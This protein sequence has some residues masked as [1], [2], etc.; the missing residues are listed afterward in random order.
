MAP[1]FS[2]RQFLTGAAALTAAPALGQVPASGEVEIAVLGAGA[3]GIAA[4]RRIA[5]AGRSYALLEAS[6]RI[7]GRVATA[8]GIF[9]IPHDRGAHRI[10]AS[11]RNPLIAL[12]RLEGLSFKEATQRR[13][14]YVGPREA[15]DSEYDDFTATLRR[16]SRAIAAIGEAGRDIAA[17]HALPDLGDWQATVS[18]ALGPLAYSKDLDQVSTIEFTRTDDRSEDFVCRE[19]L[20]RLLDAAAKPLTVKLDTPVD[21]I[22]ARGRG[23]IA[24][25]TARGTVQARTLIV[26]ASTNVLASGRIR[27]DQPPPKRTVDAL[28]SL[29]LGTHDRVVFELAGNPFRF[30]DNQR[31]IFKTNSAQTLAL[32]GRVGGTDLAYAEITG[33][34]GG[35]LSKAG[36]AAMTAFVSDFI[37]A[38]LGADVR[39]YIGRAEVVSWSGEPWIMGGKSAAAPGAGASRR[40]LAEPVHDRIFLAGEAL[41][42]SWPGTVAGAWIS[43]ERAAAAA[44]QHLL[45]PPPVEAKQLERKVRRKK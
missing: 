13:R 28:L 27:F 4:A 5:A 23:N 21:R 35:E 16:A 11:G 34:F 8:T 25:E 26:T 30:N 1:Q 33:R 9:G 42:E 3:A 17:V 43:G 41:H 29:S 24:I 44:L 32:V 12:G 6:S 45:P 37:E 20:G 7:G 19:G 18:F 22:D 39:K 2:R 40:I 36:D 15:R 14:L 31:V 38:Q 10:S